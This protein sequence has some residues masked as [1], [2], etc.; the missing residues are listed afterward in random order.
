ARRA[1]SNNSKPP[2]PALTSTS[3]TSGPGAPVTTA[4]LAHGQR[5]HHAVITCGSVVASRDH[6]VSGVLSRRHGCTRQPAAAYPSAAVSISA[7]AP[8]AG[9]DTLPLAATVVCWGRSEV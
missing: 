5:R 2:R 3:S 8:W 6:V 9:S 1:R 7:R 4:T